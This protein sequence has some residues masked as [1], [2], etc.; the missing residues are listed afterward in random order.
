[1]FEY[2]MQHA[3]GG[4]VSED[5][6]NVLGSQGWEIVSILPTGNDEYTYIFMRFIRPVTIVDTI[7][8]TEAQLKD[9]FNNVD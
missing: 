7:P 2:M 6:L 4:L 9:F 1:M 5:D 8:P 3:V